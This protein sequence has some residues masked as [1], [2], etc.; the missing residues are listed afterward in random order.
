MTQSRQQ[1]RADE[2][3]AAKLLAR[4]RKQQALKR[5]KAVRAEAKRREMLGG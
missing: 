4:S 3:R 2:R 1:Q 5:K